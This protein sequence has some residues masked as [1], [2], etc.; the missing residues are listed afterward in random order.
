MGHTSVGDVGIILETALTTGADGSSSRE[1]VVTSVSKGGPADKGG[2]RVGDVVLSIDG[3][4]VKPSCEGALDCLFEGIAGSTVSVTLRRAGTKAAKTF[5][6]IR[7]SGFGASKQ[8][9]LLLPPHD[10]NERGP[11]FACMPNPAPRML[12]NVSISFLWP[13]YIA[14]MRKQRARDPATANAVENDAA[15]RDV[16]IGYLRLVLDLKRFFE[17]GVAGDRLHALPTR[18]HQRLR[19]PP[20]P[21]SPD[22]A[23]LLEDYLLKTDGGGVVGAAKPQKSK[24]LKKWQGDGDVV[25]IARLL[26]YDGAEDSHKP[27]PAADDEDDDDDD[28]DGDDDDDEVEKGGEEGEE[29]GEEEE[30]AYK[31]TARVAPL[32]TKGESAR[33]AECPDTTRRN[34]QP[35]QS[36]VPA[37]STAHT[38]QASG[39]ALAEGVISGGGVE[40]GEE[41]HALEGKGGAVAEV[42]IPSRGKFEARTDVDL[43]LH[44]EEFDLLRD[45]D[46]LGSEGTSDI[47]SLRSHTLVALGLIHSCYWRSRF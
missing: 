3:V 20:P 32:N 2:M 44:F 30:D 7:R 42:A 25:S 28:D 22:D 11:C 39:S 46:D 4:T 38:G 45:S 34:P 26:G 24:A 14:W 13:A 21:P 37:A 47:S 41:G 17:T 6:L 43:G 18:L 8:S 10:L 15:C 1:A 31:G 9:A 36:A 23:Q 27:Q 16:K 19:L 40:G 5:D 29:T 35:L 12:G 33:N